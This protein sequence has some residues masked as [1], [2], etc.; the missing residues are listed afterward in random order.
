[1]RRHERVI[2]GIVDEL[3]LADLVVMVVVVAIQ[4]Q[5]RFALAAAEV[6]HALHLLRQRDLAKVDFVDAGEDLYQQREEVLRQPLDLRLV[7][8]AH[9][10]LQAGQ[11]NEN[12]NNY[13]P[14]DFDGMA[15]A[16]Q[17]VGYGLGQVVEQ[18]DEQQNDLD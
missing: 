4:M 8:R 12:Q 16:I 2:N 9:E 5:A 1:M 15:D 14:N 18:E 17:S 7:G 10:H 6:P 11:S 3:L 13:V